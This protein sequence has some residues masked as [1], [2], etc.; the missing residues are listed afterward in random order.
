VRVWTALVAL[1][2]MLVVA[3]QASAQ[4]VPVPPSPTQW[5][6]DSAGMLSTVTRQ[7]LNQRL[8]AYNQATGHQILV[9][10]G[11]TTG[12]VPLEDW[13]IGSFSA[14][15]VGRKG[16]DDGAVLFLFSQ[17]RKVRIEVGYGLESTLTDAVSSEIIRDQ[18]VPRMRAGDA[19]GA[20]TAGVDGILA[21]IGGEPQNTAPTAET[22]SAPA[23]NDWP[24]LA[25]FI[26][27]WIGLV[28]FNYASRRRGPYTIG[29]GYTGAGYGGFFGGGFGGGGFGGG[30][31]FSG[32]GGMG[33][34]G[35]ASGG[36]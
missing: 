12:N 1:I 19:D 30:G 5:V 2:A 31:G 15:N 25:V 13:T 35:G 36:W 33:G 4:A 29:S 16:L 9:W 21:A 8:A 11:T 22:G 14:W 10:I 7:D 26:A 3:S 32:G 18:I 23:G 17:D 28:I 27:A 6:T 24:L 34:G 20:V